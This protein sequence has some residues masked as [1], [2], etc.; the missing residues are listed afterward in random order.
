MKLAAAGLKPI[1]PVIADVGTFEV[2]DFA[3]MTKLAA[4]PRTTGAGP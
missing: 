2:A 3:R 4:P 1:F